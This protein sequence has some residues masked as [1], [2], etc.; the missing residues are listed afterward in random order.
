MEARAGAVVWTYGAPET[1]CRRDV[2]VWR[3]AARCSDIKD[4]GLEVSK[5]VVGGGHATKRH[6]PLK[7]PIIMAGAPLTLA[8]SGA[9]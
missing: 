4:G 1:R 7:V 3:N 9:H 8:G 2:E 5:V 6:D